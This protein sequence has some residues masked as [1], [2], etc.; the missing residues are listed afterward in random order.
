MKKF[1]TIFAICIII[2]E[3]THAQ[4]CNSGKLDP[5]I[6]SLLTRT[7]RDLE[8][9]LTKTSVEQIENDRVRTNT[10]YPQTDIQRIKTDSNVSLLVFNATHKKNLPV[11]IYYHPGG[12]VTPL[13]PGMEPGLWKASQDLHCIVIAVDYRIAPE[14]KFPAAV[15]DAYNA[16]KWI[17]EHAGKF[18]GDTSGIILWGL[19]AGANLAAVVCQ[20]AKKDGIQDK[21]KLQILNCPPL[22]DVRNNQ[23][24]ATY[25]KYAKGFFL[26]KEFMLFSQSLYAGKENLNH[27]EVSPLLSTNVSGLPPMLMITAEF[28]IL[29]DEAE[30]YT[31][32]LQAAGVKVQ[33]KCFAGQIHCLV[34][35]P[36]DAQ[37]W[38][39]MNQLLI[40]AIEESIH[41]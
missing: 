40:K 23:T 31:K 4:N 36:P 32:K 30:L 3:I 19:S 28:D 26:T 17:S 10:L 34:G 24:H 16:F 39:E 27:P 13:L 6:D 15:N 12:F 18:G 11:L 25:K 37:E 9:M 35:L 22:D 41:K 20:K 14:H 7:I 33:S 1:T 5:R 2:S 21:I 38:K 8:P 29:R